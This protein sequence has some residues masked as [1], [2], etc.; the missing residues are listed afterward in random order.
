[1]E[2]TSANPKLYTP[3]QIRLGS[4]LGGPIASVYFLKENFRVLGKISESRTTL[5][6]GSALVICLLASL[7]FLPAHFPN[8]VVPLAYSY[9]AGS[10]CEKWQLQKQAIV[11]SGAYQVQSGWRVL[12]LAL[13]FLLS[14]LVIGVAGYFCFSA[15]GLVNLT[16]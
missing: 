15:L 14:F 1:M 3:R 12:G 6:W 10:I 2:A 5:L 13:L 8:Y 9:V 11:D 16:K 4:F 7:S